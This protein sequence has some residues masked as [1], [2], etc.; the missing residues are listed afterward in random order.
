MFSKSVKSKIILPTSLLLVVLLIMILVDFTY[1]FDRYS[2][3]LF[4]ERIEVTAQSLKEHLEYSKH[5]S[6]M[7]A[8]AVSQNTDIINA[9][10]ERD[11]NRIKALL[12]NTLDEFA[13]DYY[14]VTDET[15]TVL[16]RT[17]SEK[18]GDSI[19]YQWN[20]REALAGKVHSC[21][22]EGSYIKVSASTCSPVYDST[23]T[24]IGVISAGVRFDTNEALDR[25]K[26]QFNAEFTVALGDTRIASTIEMDG[27]RIIGT[28]IDPDIASI[29]IDD[30]VEYYGLFNVLGVNF[31]GFD[32][33]LKNHDDEVF[34]ILF[35]G[36]SNTNLMAE[37]NSLLRNGVVTGVLG[38]C[39]SIIMLWLIIT[40]ITKP[41]KT[42]AKLVSDVTH[43][44]FQ[45]DIDTTGISR[46]EVGLL[47]Q[48]IYSLSGVIESLTGDLGQLTNDLNIYGDINYMID[49]EKY[50]G[51]YKE[52]ID[53]IKTLAD[54]ISMT[55]KTMAVV[56][57]LDTMISVVDLEYNLLYINKSMAGKFEVN[58]ENCFGHKCYKVLRELD[59]PCP[60]CQLPEMFKDLDSNP[61][62]TYHSAWDKYTGMWL[63]GR[64][65]AI[66]W[67][68][69]S[70]VFLNS[71]NDE[72]QIKL[73]ESQLSEAGER[74]ML[75]LDTSPLCTQIWNID[76]A[77]ID[78]NIA[79]VKLFGFKDKQE[80]IDKFLD[81][82]MPEFQ[83]DGQRSIEKAAMLLRKTFTEGHFHFNWMHK[84]PDDDTPIPSEVTLVKANYK[85]E[86]VVISYIRD[87]R[88]HE[89]MM[90]EIYDREAELTLQR[91][92][93]EAANQA[94]SSF[95]ANMSHE[96]RTPMNSIIGFSELALDDDIPPNTRDYLGRITKS[97]KL[98]LQ[99]INDI[100]DLSKIESGNIELEN[101]SFELHELLS[102]CQSIISTSADEKS[103]ELY[104]YADPS[105]ACK[106]LCGD[107]TRIRQVLVNLLSN[108][109]K[110]TES[111]MVSLMINTKKMNESSI[112]LQFE[113]EDTGVGMTHEQLTKI[114]DPFM[115]AD[116]STTRKYGGTGL[117]LPITKK[118]LE[119]MGS[120]LEIKSTPGFGS[121]AS[122][123]IT[124]NTTDTEGDVSE[125][126]NSRHIIEKP[127]F[128][129]CV[130]VCEDNNL[131][132]QVIHENLARVGLHAET[133]ENGKEGINM[134]KKRIS[135]GEKPYDLIFL[136]I[137][138]PVMDG[139]EATQKILA[140]NTGVPIVA[141][142]ANAMKQD[143][144]HYMKIGM[145]DYIGKPYTSQELWRCLLRHLNPVSFA[146]TSENSKS[147]DD[148][149]TRLK[150]E[151][152]KNNKTR[153]Q[154]I[155]N[156]IVTGDIKL[157]HRLAHTLKSN[158]G[159]IGEA[160][161][162][163]AAAEMESALISEPC[164]AT[165]EQLMLLETELRRVINKLDALF[166]KAGSPDVHEVLDAEQSLALLNKLEPMLKNRTPEVLN[167]LDTVRSVIGAETLV[168]Q[169][170]E[171]EFK[172]AL[173]TLL[174]LKKTWM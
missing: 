165:E 150:A 161:L 154:E 155:K 69:G 76:L 25:L 115:Q 75:M 172:A 6:M 102:S 108:A 100:L 67:I 135:K 131:N 109:V 32:M 174:Q 129:G 79:C 66:D 46:D 14:I 23:G 41:I 59:E 8:I 43:G 162:Q 96:I 120:E 68:D 152:L 28:N 33:P 82:C 136:D 9:L 52:I 10:G 50:S 139:M 90:Q 104:F 19:S 173:K 58:R 34:A 112:T 113:V 5:K 53:G 40:K 35:V 107:P 122:F 143:I 57:Y 133:A 77:T 56:D 159:L 170:E 117:G 125:N 86:N 87:L 111:G 163:S 60:V 7:A 78:C 12:I 49:T 48:D 70:K 81:N 110:F 116:V 114:F 61:V 95:V 42:A 80:Y 124:L 38:L 171:Y 30:G 73:Y 146:E 118:L 20:I 54:T 168:A 36:Q 127:V 55:K 21:V 85:G 89:Q 142:T 151:F 1:N 103:I 74:S 31:R 167:H 16:V 126:A 47:T 44:N 91:M 119:M 98:L 39:I 88:E 18:S 17:F 45:I 105:A 138:M 2:Q 26:E 72:T 11:N 147:C 145:K 24:L 92:E 166:E 137:H 149:D 63:G 37:R 99:I 62:V 3:I 101:I 84:M 71:V 132:Q 93:A 22:E 144:D 51:V 15:G 64:A 130:L 140:L 97:G 13:V 65:A 156:A 4:D 169:I 164:R 141:M 128:N 83:P 158:A 94:K 29:I 160:S 121:S 123:I 134:V 148:L 153:F 106:R 157:A 27:E